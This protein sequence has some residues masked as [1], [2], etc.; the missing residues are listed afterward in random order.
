MLHADYG[1]WY[2]YVLIPVVLLVGGATLFVLARAIV[3]APRFDQRLFN[4]VPPARDLVVE[5]LTD[6]VIVA[7][8][9]GR[10]ADLNGAAEELLGLSR[11]AAVGRPVREIM[12]EHPALVRLLEE[13]VPQDEGGAGRLDL[14][15][16]RDTGCHHYSLTVSPVARRRGESAGR[17]PC[18]WRT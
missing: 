16:R 18:C 5:N 9:R 2:S 13:G 1:P 17:L 10:I 11:K 3:R 6:G 4:I 7:D 15:L 12:A 14:T 8:D